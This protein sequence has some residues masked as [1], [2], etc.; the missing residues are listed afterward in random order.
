MSKV[1]PVNPDSYPISYR[2]DG[3]DLNKVRDMPS[4]PIGECL[5]T[6]KEWR[7]SRTGKRV[8]RPDWDKD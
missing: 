5:N 4:N 1:Q 3:I 2:R 6:H 8:E 7:D